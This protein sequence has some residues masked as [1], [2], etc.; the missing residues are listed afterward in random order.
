MVREWLQWMGRRRRRSKGKD[1]EEMSSSGGC[2]CAVF[3]IFDLPHHPFR[4]Q[5]HFLHRQSTTKSEGI[6]AP[7]NSLEVFES[8]MKEEEVE[9]DD[10]NS[11]FP[12]GIS[13][14]KTKIGSVSTKEENN[15]VFSDCSPGPIT[16]PNLVARLMGLDLLPQ[17][18]NSNSSPQTKPHK[19]KHTASD[20]ISIG[21]RRKSDFEY[22]RL[23]LQINKETQS[24][25]SAKMRGK[26]ATFNKEKARAGL[27]D[28]TNTINYGD[29]EEIIR[30][31]KNL[32]FSHKNNNAPPKIKSLLDSK[33]KTAVTSLGIKSPR[34]SGFEN[35]QPRGI[36]RDG[37]KVGVGNGNISSGLVK[38]Q[39]GP[40][41]FDYS[42]A[43]Q[44]SEAFI[45]KGRANNLKE[46]EKKK[47]KVKKESASSEIV[48]VNGPTILPVKK[49]PSP[50]ATKLPQKQ[51]QVSDALSSKRST[52]LSR[53]PGRSYKQASLQPDQISTVLPDRI[54]GC[55]TAP[56]YTDYVQK[57]LKRAGLNSRF[58]P[59]TLGKSRTASHPL[60]PSIFYHLELAAGG[61][62]ILSR[63]CNR[64]L[65]FQLADELL[66]EILKPKLDFMPWGAD[67]N[68]IAADNLDLC[69]ELCRRIGDFPAADC[70]VLE[71]IDSLIERDLRRP[72]LNS[73]FL[74]EERERLV[75]EIEG[76]I[77][78][79]LVRETAAVVR[80]GDTEEGG[81][82][83][84]RVARAE[85][86]RHVRLL[87]GNHPRGG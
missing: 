29:R 15:I 53:N 79:W 71:D 58:T 1:G 41:T 8:A 32:A 60:D 33:R 68:T 59:S 65:I 23:S 57:I 67:L 87:V 80:G 47:K 64:K 37:N 36:L 12:V 81:A 52:Q 19:H 4:Y 28:I 34:N 2:I 9:D 26:S 45:R 27:V 38:L 84:G 73:E 78:E 63:R 24:A 40:Q 61:A 6:E 51:S 69:G 85:G 11:N 35:D 22:H 55:A 30:R 66:A 70:R 72:K 10:E 48:N 42:V 13:K 7:R 56:E 3:Q 83:G 18:N 74:G 16:T 31:D 46:E 5:P 25:I 49:N 21:A 20:D 14:I 77:T 50:H 76:E 39:T 44:K 54:N 75:C 17:S 82:G 43:D 62:G 86:R